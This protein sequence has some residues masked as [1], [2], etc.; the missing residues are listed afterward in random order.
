M[1]SKKIKRDWK[2]E[3]LELRGLYN[4]LLVDYQKIEKVVDLYA[5]DIETLKARLAKHESQK[6]EENGDD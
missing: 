6:E 1:S 5:A 4:A 2:K 3:S